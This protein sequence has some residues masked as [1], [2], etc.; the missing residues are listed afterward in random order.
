MAWWDRFRSA[1]SRPPER[2]LDERLDAF[3]DAQ[4]GGEAYLEPAT[5]LSGASVVLVA[6]DGRWSRFTVPDLADARSYARRRGI[7]CYDAPVVGYPRRMREY[8]QRRKQG[9]PD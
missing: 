4:R 7:P 2:T 3:L 5:S 1:R 8:D 6:F 9:R